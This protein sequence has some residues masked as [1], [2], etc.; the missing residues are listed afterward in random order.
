MLATVQKDNQEDKNRSFEEWLKLAADNKINSSNTWNLALIDYFADLSLLK[1]GDSIN[2]QKASTTLDGCVKV[3]TSRID[4]VDLETKKL[5]VGLFDKEE[6]VEQV[7]SGT[8]D[9]KTTRKKRVAKTVETDEDLLSTKQLELDFVMDPLFKK[10]AADFDEG[11]AKGLLLNHLQIS[12]AAKII[13]DAEDAKVSSEV[14]NDALHSFSL[15][16]FQGPIMD[17]FKEMWNYKVC[18][19]FADFDFESTQDEFVL[20]PID[21]EK[22]QHVQ[23]TPMILDSV[24]EQQENMDPSNQYFDDDGGFDEPME[25][26]QPIESASGLARR[27]TLAFD[28]GE[29]E[30][31]SM[32][33]LFDKSIGRSWAGPDFWK[34]RVLK[35]STNTP[36]TKKKSPKVIQQLDFSVDAPSES[37]LF[38]KSRASINLSKTAL[39]SAGDHLLPED[40]QYNSKN[41]AHLM[42]RK[43]PIKIGRVEKFVPAEND[44]Q[45]D[46]YTTADVE[47]MMDEPMVEIEQLEDEDLMQEMPQLLPDLPLKQSMKAE[48]LNYSRK[49]KRV[50]VQKLKENLWTNLQDTSKEQFTQVVSELDEVYDEQARSEISVSYC[51]ICLLH[52]ANEQN[53]SLSSK[54]T[55]DELLIAKEVL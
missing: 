7:E 31:D 33:S 36:N 32:F 34:S 11:G 4:S 54:T 50:D 46:Y 2:F 14:E 53:L 3:Y 23:E 24:T 15:S 39:S 27:L 43:K 5:L 40:H 42:M 16:V 47:P 44:E 30:I 38:A 21:F 17:G 41:F 19:T 29:S 12:S 51:F 48:P 22:Y 20:A 35:D 13:F 6:N 10:T 25:P 55:L 45:V 8:T 9:Q 26:M 1:S 52:L 37:T 28:Q 18:P 49:A